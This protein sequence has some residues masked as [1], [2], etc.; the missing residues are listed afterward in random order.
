VASDR[1]PAAGEIEGVLS[2]HGYTVF[3]AHTGRIAFQAT[4]SAQP[5]VVIVDSV[6]PD[7]DGFSLCGKLRDDPEVGPSRPILMMLGDR[8]TLGEHRSAMRVGIWEFLIR[9]IHPD[10]LTGRVDAYVLAAMETQQGSAERALTDE[11]GFYTPDGLARRA[12]ELALQAFH[13]HAGFACLVISPDR[14]EDVDR[15]GQRL[16]EIARRSDAIGRLS[17]SS[18]AIVA[19]G[20][21]SRGVQLLAE[22]VAREIRRI[23]EEDKPAPTLKAGFDAVGNIRR[24]PLEARNMLDRAAV[25]LQR[26]IESHRGDW[27]RAYD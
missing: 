12:K 10:E 20:T 2:R 27:I 16:K 24:A 25:A 3:R 19:P 14:P 22:R 5:E 21:D 9:P 17:T 7:T 15:V 13:H 4:R 6:L 1:E 8:P 26:A 23:N 18:F 11:T